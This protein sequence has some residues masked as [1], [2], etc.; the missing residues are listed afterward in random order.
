MLHGVHY[1]DRY[2]QLDTL[3]RITDPWDL[4]SPREHFRFE[5]TNRLIQREFGNVARLL[6]VGC[7]EGYQS[8]YLAR[9]CDRLHGCD[10]SVRAVE[11]ARKR[12]EPSTFSVSTL[13][14]IFACGGPRYDLV[15]ACEVLYYIEDVHGTI[16]IMSQLG[17][18]CL[19]T[20]YKSHQERLDPTINALKLAGRTIMSYGDDTWT[21]AWWHNR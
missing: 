1:R 7:G 6:E 5:E 4:D 8:Q 19:V 12:A 20:Y 18:S 10:V 16:Q 17:T 9:I 13:N 3:Y 11:R 2:H 14:D 21:A 15:V